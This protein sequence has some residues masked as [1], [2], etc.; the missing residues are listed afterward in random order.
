M[1]KISGQDPY[2]AILD[3]RNTPI[4][5]LNSSPAQRLLSRR[6][7]MLL[8]IR[9]SLLE[10]RVTDATAGLRIN[11]E[12]QAK[13]YNHTAKDMDALEQGDSVRV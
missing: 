10:P 7:R 4:Q 1:A 11:E 9:E 2:L 8:S 6:M 13:Y 12:R 3:H 5:E